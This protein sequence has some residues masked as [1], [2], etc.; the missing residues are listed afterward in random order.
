MSE[1]YDVKWVEYWDFL[2]CYCNLKT[3]EGL[4]KLENYL[5]QKLFE[6]LLNNQVKAC[7]TIKR[8]FN[9]KLS[10]EELFAELDGILEK[11]YMLKNELGMVEYCLSEKFEKTQSI[12]ES[13][14]S[15]KEKKRR[16]V[17]HN[18][19]SLSKINNHDEFLKT[20]E[21]E[22]QLNGLQERIQDYFKVIVNAIYADK[23]AI[24]YFYLYKSAKR[25]VSLLNYNDFVT[26]YYL[27][28]YFKHLEVKQKP[29]S[30]H[31][32]VQSLIENAFKSLKLDDKTKAD[33]DTICQKL[34]LVNFNDTKNVHDDEEEDYLRSYQKQNVKAKYYQVRKRA[35]D[36]GYE[37]NN[38]VETSD[39][40]DTNENISKMKSRNICRYFD[41]FNYN[42]IKSSQNLFIFGY[43]LKL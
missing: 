43:L 25:V 16:E 17:F 37:S 4:K 42:Q 40:D 14:G 24:V 36:V 13:F 38:E 34:S 9:L 18:P 29:S 23:S 41:Q 21:T 30:Y 8:M 26:D 10:E 2:G 1:E 5:K 19:E 35:A 15:Y 20:I 12:K 27:S 22:L 11:I 39:E 31:V 3:A 28:S 7:Q 6:N 33:I 32:D